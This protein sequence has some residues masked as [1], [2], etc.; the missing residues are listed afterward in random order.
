[1]DICPVC[2]SVLTFPHD[3]RTDLGGIDDGPPDWVWKPGVRKPHRRPPVKS[4]QE[5]AD[6]RGRAWATRRAK[7]GERGHA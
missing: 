6:I 2:A 7:Y 5:S 3:H 4:P 1:M